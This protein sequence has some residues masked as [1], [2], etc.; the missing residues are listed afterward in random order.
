MKTFK[1][2][3]IYLKENK[4]SSA[5]PVELLP[6]PETVFIPL[7]Q[8]Y[9][10][11]AKLL[12]GPGAKVKVGQ[13]IALGE[14]C[15]SANVHSSVSGTVLRTEEI[16]GLSG[17]NI[18]AVVIAVEGD[19]WLETIDRSLSLN[20]S[21]ELTTGEIIQKVKD[22]GIV[23]LGGAAFPSHI[24]LTVPEGKKVEILII[25]GA[26]CEPYLTADH[27][28]ML[29]KTEEILVGALL[30]MKALNVARTIIGIEANKPAA[31][32]RFRE[33]LPKY[34]GI[35]VRPLKT[36]YP[37]GGEKQLIK[38]LTNREVPSRKLP[39]DV[40]CIVHNT[41][42]VFAVYE[43]MQKNKPLFERVVTVSGKSVNRP[44]NFLVRIGTPVSHLLEN[45][46]GVKDNVKS[47]I[48]G[49]PMMGQKIIS[50]QTP[51]IKGAT[52]IVALSAEDTRA[53][54]ER[55][56]IRCGTCIGVC[57]MGLEP[58][59]IAALSENGNYDRAMIDGIKDCIECGACDYICPS[60]RHL[61]ESIRAGKLKT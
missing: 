54:P 57:P 20:E 23:G 6:L 7:L 22:S 25:N 5:R 42:T 35:E 55:N 34:N 19:E 13:L 61:L 48:A 4:L 43:A 38:V 15:I 39:A 51:V 36:K 14:E 29:E 33:F 16:T 18:N 31:I 8:H 41:A 60:S 46:G 28:L 17:K 30:L 58:C 40:G 45:A 9:G 1:K 11:E 47:I 27:R 24:K 21:I 52:G 3:G 10:A 32:S 50:L 37:Q 56:C 49:G 2:G 59:L 44:S 26:E 53:V 12:V